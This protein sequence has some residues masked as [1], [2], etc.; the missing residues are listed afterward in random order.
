MPA[1]SKTIV[2]GEVVVVS[3][4]RLEGPGPGIPS[5]ACQEHVRVAQRA[6]RD[7]PRGAC[8]VVCVWGVFYK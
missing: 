6:F 3:R 7:Q 2:R 5:P 8:Q 1:S 4:Q